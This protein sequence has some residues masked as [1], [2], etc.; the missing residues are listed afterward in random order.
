MVQFTQ[1]KKHI[2]LNKIS[3]KRTKDTQNFQV[4][5]N[6]SEKKSLIL[7]LPRKSALLVEERAPKRRVSLHGTRIYI[8]IVQT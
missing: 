7:S 6:R 3:Y 4:S 2:R 5:Y 1:T 8:R